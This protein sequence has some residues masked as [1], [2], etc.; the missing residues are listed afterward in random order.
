LEAR[1]VAVADVF[2][3]LTA[4]VLTRRLGIMTRLRDTEEDA[5]EQL[6]RDCVDAMLSQREAI[7]VIQQQFRENIYG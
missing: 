5:G 7:E 1:I 3:A 4:G 2:D 6:D